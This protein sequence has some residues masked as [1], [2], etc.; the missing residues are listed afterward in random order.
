M[1]QIVMPLCT[2]LKLNTRLFINCLEG[3]DEVTARKRP[4]DSTNNI[5]YVACHILDSRYY[6]AKYLGRNVDNPLNQLLDGV[7]ITRRV[8]ELELTVLP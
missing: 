1:N 8:G 5:S 2:I 7:A 3:V 4:G 6:L